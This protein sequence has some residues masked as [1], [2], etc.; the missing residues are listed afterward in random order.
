[1]TTPASSQSSGRY[2]TLDGLRGLAAIAVAIFHLD[3]RIMPGGYLAVYFFFALSGFVL[4]R[5]Y[6]PRWGRELDARAFVRLRLVRLLPL[7][8]IGIL[9]GSIFVVQGIVRGSDF[10]LD[11]VT[12]ALSLPLNLVMLPSPFDPNL[13]PVNLPAWSLFFELLANVLMALVLFRLGRGALAALILLAGAG[14]VLA[15]AGPAFLPRTLAVP[16]SLNAGVRWDMFHVGALRTLFAFAAGMALASL[17]APAPRAQGHAAW[18]CGAVLLAL[19]AWPF[20]GEARKM[21]DLAIA[22]VA[23]PLLVAGGS[24]V[25]PPAFLRRP[26]IFIGDV[27]FALYAVHPPIAA[28]SKFVV[29]KLSLPPAVNVALFLGMALVVAWFCTR[30]LDQPLRER[31][32][33]WLPGR[34]R[35]AARA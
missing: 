33:R 31:L 16:P 9:L 11:P 21:A 15:V 26:A 5:T 27:S 3:G 35:L 10:H 25:E 22:L 18:L 29:R 13:F 19:L 32:G 6:G 20:P 24:R 12:F 1:M 2:V 30:Y 7:H 23:L 34:G 8:A 17:Q 4:L 28:A 14:L